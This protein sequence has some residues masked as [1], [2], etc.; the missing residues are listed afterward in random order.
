M[1]E[2][3][4]TALQTIRGLRAT[5]VDPANLPSA[6]EIAASNN[7]TVVLNTDFKVDLM[8]A[9]NVDSTLTVTQI[10]LNVYFAGL[11]ANPSG[12]RTL[13][14]LIAFDNEFSAL[15]EPVNFTDQSQ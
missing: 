7:E 1:N 8:A 5:V 14:D 10:Q 11:L 9:S 12:V 6:D 15:E 3:F 2:V 13:A 4:E